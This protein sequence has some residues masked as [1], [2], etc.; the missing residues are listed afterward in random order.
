MP[1]LEEPTCATCMYFDL[2][3]T[4][5][6][7]RCR[8][9]PPIIAENVL[10]ERYADETEPADKKVYFASFFPVVTSHEWCGEHFDLRDC[11]GP[12][13]P[14]DGEKVVPLRSVA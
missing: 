2:S 3:E 13:D 4:E 6:L 12:V 5:G 10:A 9:K 1:D 7:G 14:D 8:R 11:G